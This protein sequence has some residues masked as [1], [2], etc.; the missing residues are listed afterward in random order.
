MLKF[1]LFFPALF[2]VAGVFAQQQL[3]LIPVKVQKKIIKAKPVSES[4]IENPFASPDN[5]YVDAISAY[6]DDTIGHTHY[7]LQ[8]TCSAPGGRMTLFPDGTLAAVWTRGVSPSA[9]SDRGTGYNY[10]DG[11]I[12]GS[13]D[14]ERL[15]NQKAGWPS[16]AQLGQEGEVVVSHRSGLPSEL[17]F[18]KRDI[19]GTGEWQQSAIP[20][21]ENAP[22]LLWPRMVTGGPDKDQIH[23]ISLATPIA[24]NGALYHGQDG[25]LIYT[26]SLDGG[27]T[28]DKNDVIPGLDSAY[29]PGWESDKYSLAEPRGNSLAFAINHSFNDLV[30]MKSTDNGDTWQKTVVWRYPDQ[31]GDFIYKPDGAVSVVIDF[32]DKVHLFFG[33]VL[34]N[35]AGDLFPYQSGIAY[36]NEDLPVWDGDDSYLANCLNPDTLDTEGLLVAYPYDVNGNGTWDVLGECGDYNVG[37]VSMPQAT[38][39]PSGYGILV[40]SAVTETYNYM[41]MDYRHI[42][43]MEAQNNFEHFWLPYDYTAFYDSD[44]I[45]ECVFPSVCQQYNP[46]LLGDFRFIYQVDRFPGLQGGADASEN[47]IINT[48]YQ[49]IPNPPGTGEPDEA[50]LLVSQNYPNPFNG[51]T[52]VDVSIKVPVALAIVVT[53]ITGRTVLAKEYGSMPAGQHT[54]GIDASGLSA[55]VYFYTV[56][57][58]SAKMTKKMV[59]R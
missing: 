13:I 8:S 45:A 17:F 6:L 40:Y 49:I 48:G 47:Y 24:N 54:L 39:D 12:W 27:V 30:L 55:G 34:S 10:F 37:A 5:L 19:K 18:Q 7:D 2:I 23:I 35:A 4:E 29:Y 16:H 1:L 15:E 44:T 41:G 56:R 11:T 42:W 43:V 33:I 3:P 53:D 9:Y 50:K 58:G 14:P 20:L 26:R 52:Y 25:A 51:T 32:H 28:W 38:I 57:A 59:V 46:D 31:A 36:W 22:G 21:P